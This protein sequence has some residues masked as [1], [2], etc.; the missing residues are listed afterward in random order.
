[1]KLEKFQ[2]VLD[3][4]LIEAVFING[5]CVDVDVADE[6]CGKRSSSWQ[7]SL[8][9]YLQDIYNREHGYGYD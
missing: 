7:A 3:D 2:Y 8:K 9:E 5:E 1:M 6:S 4:V